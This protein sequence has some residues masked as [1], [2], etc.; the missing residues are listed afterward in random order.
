MSD[1]MGK[2]TSFAWRENFELRADHYVYI[3]TVFYYHTYYGKESLLLLSTFYENIQQNFP[4]SIL[5]V[6]ELFLKIMKNYITTRIIF[7]FLLGFLMIIQGIKAG[8]NE[9]PKTLQIGIFS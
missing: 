4:E 3:Y 5:C 7:L 1:L 2:I 9:P 6:I 8:D